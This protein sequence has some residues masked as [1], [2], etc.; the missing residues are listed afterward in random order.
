MAP[1]RKNSKRNDLTLDTKYKVVK[2][3][4]KDKTLGIRKLGEMFKCGKTQISMILKN[5]DKIEELNTVNASG[6]RCHT[7]KRLRESKF[8]E[9]N[10]VLHKWYLLAVPKNIFPNG[11][12]LAE[13]AKEIASTLGLDDFKASNGWLDRW[14]KKHNLKKM[15]ISGESGY[16]SGDTVDSWKQRLPEIV[17]GYSTEDVWNLDES[18]VYWRTL[19]DKGFGQRVKECKGGKKSKH[20]FTVTFIVRFPNFFF[21]VTYI[22]N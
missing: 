13:K 20:R 6:Q 15:T 9:L 22:I 2:T 4:E 21:Q 10:Q 5:K 19:P 18:G 7:G 11:V 12:H 1:K 3:A 14:K 17:K 8:S 16:V